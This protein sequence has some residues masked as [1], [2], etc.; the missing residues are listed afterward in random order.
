MVDCND[1]A[2]GEATIRLADRACDSPGKNTRPVSALLSAAL[3][4]LSYI[5][6]VSINSRISLIM[7]LCNDVS[8]IRRVLNA[9][10][11]NDEG[12]VNDEL[13]C[14]SARIHSGRNIS[15]DAIKANEPAC[16]HPILTIIA[17]VEYSYIYHRFTNLLR[18]AS[19]WQ[20][21]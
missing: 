19:R 9:V 13:P 20:E 1:L 6:G 11:N 15:T 5:F 10:E 4:I 14:G 12:V 21:N 8:N 3:V 18:V 16:R 17:S 7:E 2:L